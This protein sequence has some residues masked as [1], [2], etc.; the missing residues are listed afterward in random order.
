MDANALLREDQRGGLEIGPPIDSLP[1]VFN[2]AE[3]AILDAEAEEHELER[4]VSMG[5]LKEQDPTLASEK[6]TVTFVHTWKHGGERPGW[7]RRARLVAGQYKWA[8]LMG[9][10]E[11][12]SPASVVPLARHLLL[13]AQNWDT[14]IWVCDV[15]DAYLNVAQPEDEPVVVMV[16]GK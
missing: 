16:S 3:L 12:F 11:T 15:K 5:V 7:W 1:P 9:D 10:E 2:E 13:L 14:P 8:S 6:L 4:L